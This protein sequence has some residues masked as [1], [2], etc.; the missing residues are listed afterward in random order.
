MNQFFTYL[1]LAGLTLS[2]S[3]CKPTYRKVPRKPAPEQ[4]QTEHQQTEQQ[5]QQQTQ[6]PA[7]PGP[8]AGKTAQE[9]PHSYADSLMEVRYVTQKYETLRPWEKNNPDTDLASAVY[10]GDG[11]VL[12]TGISAEDVTYVELSL[13]DGSRT[14]PARIV[15][16]DADLELTLLAVAHEQDN[17]I[18]ETR[19][20]YPIG[21]PLQPGDKAELWCLVNGTIPT[22]IALH[23]ESAV[24]NGIIPFISAKAAQPL[25]DGLYACGAPVILGGKLVALS[26]SYDKETQSV[27]CLNAE[28]LQ[29]FLDEESTTNSTPILGIQFATL[30]DPVFRRYLKLDDEQCGLY[31]HNVLPAG[32]A[33]AAGIEKGDVLTSVEGQPLDNQGRWQ[34]PIYGPVDA[35]AVIRSLKPM[36]GQI[37]LGI[38]RDGEQREVTVNLNRDAADKAL[39][40]IEK[41]GVPS[42]YIV[43]GGMLF[44]PVTRQFLETLRAQARSLPVQFL[45]IERR[46]REF[47][48]KG[49]T[50]IVALT[51]VI[52]TPATLGYE[53]VAFSIVEKVNGKEI[54]DFREFEEA[55]DAPTPDGLL[56][57][58]INRAPYDIYIDRQTAEAANDA[59]RRNAI[60]NLRRTG[61]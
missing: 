48:D 2:V 11:K 36:G 32:A 18:F 47:R 13:P 1:A 31:I 15:K 33:A 60:H 42:R 49:V 46:E 7:Q 23:A 38:S 12:A 25:P 27:D 52:P 30:D 50:E 6:Q 55:L 19:R 37:K 29:R 54:H 44:R 20:A 28:F 5:E 26:S 58:T 41:P 10:I 17:T 22:S 56:H 35:G 59:L 53:S 40:G 16:Y 24:D 51:L 3:A 45:E 43:W 34:H 61:E 21:T 9:A 4:Q 8:A 57:L 39:P 14:V